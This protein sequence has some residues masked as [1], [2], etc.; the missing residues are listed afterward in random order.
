ML[1]Q[2]PHERAHKF[3]DICF[4]FLNLLCN[5]VNVHQVTEE[6]RVV[7]QEIYQNRALKTFLLGLRDYLGTIIRCIPPLSEAF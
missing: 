2:L 1:R 7:K 5:Y 4:H 3:Y 6:A